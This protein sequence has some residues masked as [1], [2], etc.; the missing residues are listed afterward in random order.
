MFWH[1]IPLIILENTLAGTMIIFVLFYGVQH[2]LMNAFAELTLFADRKFYNVRSSSL[3]ILIFQILFLHILLSL[4]IGFYSIILLSIRI[5][6]F[7]PHTNVTTE[8]GT[9]QY[10]TGSTHTSSKTFTKT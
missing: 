6:G 8:I 1:D 2:A 9:S 5:G 7:L 3:I 4:T 10:T